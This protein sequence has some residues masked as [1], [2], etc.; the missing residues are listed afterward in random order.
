MILWGTA[1]LAW[2]GAV[3]QITAHGN[4][5]LITGLLVLSI[6]FSLLRGWNETSDVRS[7]T[8]LEWSQLGMGYRFSRARDALIMHGCPHQ[9][10]ERCHHCSGAQCPNL[11]LG[12]GRVTT[13]RSGRIL[14]TQC[15]RHTK[16][17]S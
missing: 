17:P 1:F 5:M 10:C 8:R 2:A 11:I 12:H 6:V 16:G 7:Q 14:H 3:Y 4:T 15:R 9:I 13:D